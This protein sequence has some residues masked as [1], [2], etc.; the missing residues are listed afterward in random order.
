[1][2]RFQTDDTP[3]DQIWLC[4]HLGQKKITFTTFKGNKRFM[5]CFAKIVYL[6]PLK[7][8][9]II[10]HQFGWNY[11]NGL[12]ILHFKHILRKA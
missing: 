2:L 6:R 8:K 1:V 3:V 5:Y 11:W 12:P 7:L 10:E 4:T 9:L